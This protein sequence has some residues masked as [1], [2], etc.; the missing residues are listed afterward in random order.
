M[1]FCGE[2]VSRESVKDTKLLP[3]K[4]TKALHTNVLC[5][6]LAMFLMIF[7]I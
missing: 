1:C 4:K 6:F 5:H 3:V 7:V 2:G